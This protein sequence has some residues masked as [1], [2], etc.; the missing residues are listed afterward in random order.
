MPLH[1]HLRANEHGPLRPRE[2]LERSTQLLGLLDGVGVEADHL[3]LGH[4]LRE[5]ALELLRARADARELGRP[6]RGA[7]LPKRLDM[8]AVMAAQ[9]VVTVQRQRDITVQA[10]ACR[11]A[12][13]A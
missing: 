2:T 11:A 9:R 3:E 4:L 12:R 7:R 6:A 13:A 10:A 5:L 8:P 1:D